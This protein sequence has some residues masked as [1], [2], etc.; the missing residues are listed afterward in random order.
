MAFA[1]YASATIKP[2]VPSP[3]DPDLPMPD[4]ASE[5]PGILTDANKNRIMEQAQQVCT[6][7]TPSCGNFCSRHTI[8]S[9]SATDRADKQMEHT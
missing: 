5:A 4:T 9:S 2:F 1:K 8:G 3:C 7:W 6:T